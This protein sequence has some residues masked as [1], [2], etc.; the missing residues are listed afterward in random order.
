[1]ALIASA[2]IGVIAVPT[3]RAD[4][5]PAD[6]TDPRTPPT[7]AMD[8]LPTAQHNGVAWAQVVVGNT[9]YVVGRFTSARPAGSPLGQGEVT[10][11]NALAYDLL[12]GQLKPAFNPNLNGQ[13]LAVT[14]SPDG[15]R[16]YVGGEFTSVGGTP[17]SRIAALD[18]VT[19]AMITSFNARADGPVKAIAATAS[20]VYVGGLFTRVNDISRARMAAL[21][22]SN[23]GLIAGFAPVFTGN[24][25]S[26]PR[27]NAIALSPT[28][29]R[30]VIGGNFVTVNGS[31]NP[32]YGL[33]MIDAGTGASLPMPANSVVRDAGKDSA[34]LSLASDGVNVYGTG[35]IF[36]IGGNLEGAFSANWSNGAI[37]WIEDC[38]GDSYGVYPS[39]TAVYVASHAHYCLN[40][41]GYN[42]T[43][44]PMRATA[45]SKAAT[46]VLT[47]DTRG[48]FSFTG[49]PAP[50][51]LNYFPQLVS[52][53][54]S[55]QGQAAWAVAGNAKYVVYAGEFLSVNG[56]AQ[57]G[58]VRMATPDIAPNLQGPKASAAEFTPTLTSPA[59]GQV[60]VAWTADFDYDNSDLVY[61]VLRDNLPTPVATITRAST[62]WQR[63]AMTFTD[64]GVPGGPHNYRVRATDP[65][66]NSHTSSPV[67]ITVASG[68]NVAPV[69][70][71]SVVVSTR[72]ASVDG[73]G[74]SDPDGTIASYAWNWGDGQNDTGSKASHTYAAD[75]TYTITLT[76]TDNGGAQGTTS[77][78][79]TIGT[80]PPVLASDGF[81][82]T[83]TSGFGT[84]DVGGA[85]S[86]NGSSFAVNG[87][88]A[89]VTVS[90]AGQGPWAQLGGVSST[91]VDLAAGIRLDKRV[92]TGAA[93]MGTIGRRVGSSDYRLKVR[94]DP[95]GAVMVYAIRLA[96]GE[97]TLTS[98]V[99]PGL[100]YQAGAL[101]NT[102]LQVTGTAPTTIRARVW[103]STAVE[104]TTWQVTATDSTAA[105]Q[106]AGA[107]GLFTYISGA[108]TNTPWV[109]RF[110]DFVA[111]P[112]GG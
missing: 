70:A 20:T 46:G 112:S 32:G 25:D 10:R 36:G 18:P 105:L 26:S 23:G 97:T 101:L 4:S 53:S 87:S 58:M 40:L 38:H 76:V 54:A 13:A 22:A 35:Y 73:A 69:A 7:V 98:V 62:W 94:V 3:A 12:T 89:V 15:S 21:R 17:R 99:V 2:A 52:G 108:S 19:G 81:G 33:A 100:T 66:G 68:G 43:Q 9:V 60:K 51:L 42:E 104:P 91:A 6:P 27:V 44:P 24:P 57:Q 30:I 71:F 72:T 34:I 67:A 106:T 78:T 55:G 102:R 5:A 29:D 1:M 92:N 85:W 11:N 111:R 79:V 75:G 95:A 41:G 80:A 107:V 48:Y 49:Q 74:S 14:A 84:S 65:F 103:L 59:A 77:K 31:G 90:T 63:P 93:F 86:T 64:N 45:F 96:G 83:V 28:A 16:I 37:K 109:F 47:K 110:D 50:T 39:P 56:T 82:R 61:T 8:R 88:Q